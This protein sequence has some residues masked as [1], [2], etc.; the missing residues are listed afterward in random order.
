MKQKILIWILR[1][2]QKYVY[3]E[4]FHESS[5]KYVYE[6]FMTLLLG[7]NAVHREMFDEMLLIQDNGAYLITSR[8]YEIFLT[9][10]Q[11]S[12]LVSRDNA[13][14]LTQ[15]IY[16][17]NVHYFQFLLQESYKAWKDF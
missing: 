3:I 5:E 9:I 4:K 1:Y 15:Q 2:I 11:D 12:M 16:P 14:F 10:L 8:D 13:D 6:T 7:A 17:M